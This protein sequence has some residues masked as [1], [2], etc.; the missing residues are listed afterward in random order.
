MKITR[1]LSGFLCLMLVMSFA[2]PASAAV[3]N[4][5]FSFAL[6]NTG[7]EF[8]P[9]IMGNE[10][11]KTQPYDPATIYCADTN[12]PGWGFYIFL[13]STVGGFETNKYWYNNTNKLRHPTY[14][15]LNGANG[16]DYKVWGRIDNDYNEYYYI[17]GEFNADHTNAP[18]N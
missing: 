16:R 10:N 14:V 4:P 2:A 11:H 13:R 17:N 7:T 8:K 9:D 5:E 15:N 6:T 12:A 1:I 3:I 18:T